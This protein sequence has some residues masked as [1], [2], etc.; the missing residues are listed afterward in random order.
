VT[1]TLWRVT[2]RR[3]QNDPMHPAFLPPRRPLWQSLVL[4]AIGP[5]LA[6]GFLIYLIVW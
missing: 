6:I 5:L 1:L 4:S 3:V 2:I